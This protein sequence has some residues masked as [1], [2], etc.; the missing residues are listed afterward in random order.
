[1]VIRYDHEVSEKETKL[2]SAYFQAFTINP[3]P[4]S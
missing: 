1:L 3:V 2:H 4:V